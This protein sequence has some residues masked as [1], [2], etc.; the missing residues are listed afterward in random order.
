MHMLL[1]YA[2]QEILAS[3]VNR[4]S[5]YWIGP[6]SFSELRKFG[7][8]GTQVELQLILVTYS[9]FLFTLLHLRTSKGFYRWNVF[10]S[11]EPDIVQ[12]ISNK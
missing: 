10:K 5:C 3:N 11:K 8:W 9:K 2:L 4:Y 6:G 12:E 7:E 1:R